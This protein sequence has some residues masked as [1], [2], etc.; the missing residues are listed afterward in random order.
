MCVSTSYIHDNIMILLIMAFKCLVKILKTCVNCTGLQEENC[1][2][3]RKMF[4]SRKLTGVGTLLPVSI[5]LLIKWEH[6]HVYC[7][8]W[9][10]RLY[11]TSQHTNTLHTIHTHTH[12][13]TYIY[14]YIYIFLWG[15][16]YWNSCGIFRFRYIKLQ[17]EIS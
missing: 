7:D 15:K 6:K 1:I 12:T 8:Q 9:T 17:L 2:S 10:Q 4:N 16:C 5:L 3:G 11:F 14:I 13:H